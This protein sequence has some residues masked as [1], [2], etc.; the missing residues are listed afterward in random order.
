MNSTVYHKLLTMALLKGESLVLPDN[1]TLNEKFK[2]HGD[3]KIPEGK[4]PS[5]KYF[6]I[7]N[8]GENVV[9]DAIKKSSYSPTQGTF[10]HIPLIMRELSLDL[11]PQQRM[12]YRMRAEVDINGTIYAVY[13][14]KV[15]SNI[16]NKSLAYEVT[17]R[18]GIPTMTPYNFN[19]PEIL[20]PKEKISSG[21]ISDDENK[22]ITIKSQIELILSTSELEE[23]KKSLRILYGDDTSYAVTEIGVFSGYEMTFGANKEAI[24]SQAML[25]APLEYDVQSLLLDDKDLTKVLELGGMESVIN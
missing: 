1:T 3:I 7:G 25:F 10:K 16:E 6:S 18:D 19:D 21:K 2:V 24:G 5:L 13:Y 14:L 15:I 20:N 17:V 8:G 22:F 23:V 11:T 12:N 9:Y 4:Y